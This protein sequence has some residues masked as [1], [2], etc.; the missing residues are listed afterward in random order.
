MPIRPNDGRARPASRTLVLHPACNLL[1]VTAAGTTLAWGKAQLAATFQFHWFQS[2]SCLQHWQKMNAAVLHA[3]LGPPGAA[4]VPEAGQARTSMGPP[5]SRLPSLWPPPAGQALQDA[6]PSEARPSSSA[7]AAD[8]RRGLGPQGGGRDFEGVQEAATAAADQPKEAASDMGNVLETVGFTQEDDAAAAA[9]GAAQPS[10][11]VRNPPRPQSLPQPGSL[12]GAVAPGSH[13]QADPGGQRVAAGGHAQTRPFDQDLGCSSRHPTEPTGT[14]MAARAPGMPAGPDPLVNSPEA[15]AAAPQQQCRSPNVSSPQGPIEAEP[16]ASPHPRPEPAHPLAV[17]ASTPHTPAGGMCPT[18]D[19]SMLPEHP[20]MSRSLQA[21]IGGAGGLLDM[22]EGGPRHQGTPSG[23]LQSV[24]VADAE[25]RS[26][27]R[28]PAAPTAPNVSHPLEPLLAA[29]PRLRPPAH[30]PPAPAPL[31]QPD[32]CD[33]AQDP[34]EAP[35]ALPK[36]LGGGDQPGIP[37]RVAA[38]AAATA[39]PIRKLPRSMQ[40]A[41]VSGR[42]GPDTANPQQQPHLPGAPPLGPEPPTA[43]LVRQACCILLSC[44]PCCERMG[45][46]HGISRI[47]AC[48]GTH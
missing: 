42:S 31:P 10:L 2:R 18:F 45:I 35:E 4:A 16:G 44:T 30:S 39:R 9:W 17:D 14:S 29:S 19:L 6:A 7:A 48:D 8:S 36:P 12:N 24:Q 13:H 11:A 37:A 43:A 41:P 5:A 15:L 33:R 47:A 26:Q 38:G 21:L 28:R 34:T 27:Q 23:A 3:G 1:G 25:S 22:M 40:H 32:G 46:L 20:A